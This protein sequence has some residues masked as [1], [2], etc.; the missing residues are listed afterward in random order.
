MSF[1]TPTDAELVVV[2]MDQAA[3]L[4]AS[5]LRLHAHLT[6]HHRDRFPGAWRIT[7]VDHASS[8][9]T[10]AVAVGL[11]SDLTGISA[12]H[13][14]ERLDRRAFLAAW[15]RTRTTTTVFLT[16]T[17]HRD[18]AL[19]LAPLVGPRRETVGPA[20]KPFCDDVFTDAVFAS[21]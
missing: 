12:R 11:A 4:E 21:A 18:L 1:P 2:A 19:A 3:T 10:M 6:E 17:P 9:H 14:P 15:S 8:D 13:L 7:V 20:G 16:L 5:V